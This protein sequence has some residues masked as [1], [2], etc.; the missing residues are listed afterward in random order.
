M[1]RWLDDPMA[2]WLDFW[3]TLREAIRGSQQDFTEGS[4]GRAIIL[5]AVPMVMEM[6]M[7]SLFA[8]VDVFFVS[9]LGADAVATVGITES[10]MALVYA[11]AMGLS[12]G[13]MAMIA[14]RIGEKDPERASITAVQ[15][16]SLAILLSLPIGAAGTVLAPKLLGLMG[17]S[18]QVIKTGSRFTALILGANGIILLLFLIN[19]IFRAAGDA[20]VAM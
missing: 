15:A 18:A 9:K 19:A 14:R 12:M 3:S 16:I 5:L 11:L 10:M 20:A 7:E 4:I 1:A 2:R 13:A 17:A 8:V 6:A